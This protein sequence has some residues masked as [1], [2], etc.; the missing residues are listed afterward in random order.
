[1]PVTNKKRKREAEDEVTKEEPKR[2]TEVE[3][4]DSDSLGG[5]CDEH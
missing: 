3:I 4:S 1:M 5:S 2:A